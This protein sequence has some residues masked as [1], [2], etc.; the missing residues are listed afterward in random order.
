MTHQITADQAATLL[1]IAHEHRPAFV[2]LV[3]RMQT[4]AAVE[5]ELQQL[6]DELEAVNDALHA[7]GIDYPTGAR[8]VRDLGN[9]M[10]G[11]L[12]ARD[13]A[14]AEAAA[15]GLQAAGPLS[16][17]EGYLRGDGA[18]VVYDGAAK[19]HRAWPGSTVHEVRATVVRHEPEHDDLSRPLFMSDP[20]V[21]VELEATTAMPA[22]DTWS[23]PRPV[24]R[25]EEWV[26]TLPP[27]P[28]SADVPV[29]LTGQAV[30]ADSN[31]GGWWSARLQVL[32][33]SI[34]G[35]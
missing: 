21:Y 4:P 33:A 9:L 34:P 32:S 26:V 28:G 19:L 30:K 7:H 20:S 27:P 8:G 16:G 35:R 18:R 12:T 23:Y 22:D 10:R 24:S 13:E 2:L 11:A 15:Q 6:R 5:N 14:R 3:A 25:R 17:H 29:V 31:P 1:G